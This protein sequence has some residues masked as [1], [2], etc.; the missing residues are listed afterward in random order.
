MPPIIGHL[1]VP[2]CIY[3]ALSWVWILAQQVLA[4][5]KF[6]E[7]RLAERCECIW[8]HCA[9]LGASTSVLGKERAT[10]L[11]IMQIEGAADIIIICV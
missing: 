11:S 2:Q 4:R 1:D 9:D 7:Y 5:F 3:N 6:V 8:G 10:E